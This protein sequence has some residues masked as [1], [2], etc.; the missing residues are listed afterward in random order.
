[1]IV[2]DCIII[3]NKTVD[4]IVPVHEAQLITYLKLSNLHLGFLLNWKSLDETWYQANG[5]IKYG[6]NLGE[7]S[8]YLCDLRFFAVKHRYQKYGAKNEIYRLNH[9]TGD[10]HPAL[11]HV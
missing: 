9:P 6:T 11:A 5:F 8:K 7:P 4:Q 1:M 2:E 3:E 10:C